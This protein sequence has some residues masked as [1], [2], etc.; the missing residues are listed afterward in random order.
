MK[1]E[2]RGID[3]ELFIFLCK[4][5]E[6]APTHQTLDINLSYLGKGEVGIKLKPGLGLTTVKGR[7]H[8]GIIATVAD[9]AMGWA[10]LS[11]GRTCVTVDMYINYFNPIFWDNELLAEGCIVYAGNRTVVTEAT[12]YNEKDDLIAKSR[13]TFALKKGGIQEYDQSM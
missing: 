4:Q 5:W 1:V 7:I 11:L 3:E 9:T 12:L 2:N 8:G 13:G 6:A 10:I